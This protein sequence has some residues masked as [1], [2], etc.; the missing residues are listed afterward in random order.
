MNSRTLW[1]IMIVCALN[2][3]AIGEES[4]RQ[5]SQLLDAGS[6]RKAKAVLESVLNHEPQN[7][8]AHELLGDAY[9]HEGNAGAAE[10]EYKKAL[11]LGIRDSELLSNLATVNRWNHHFAEAR[12]LYKRELEFSPFPQDAQRE[13]D[14]LAYQ[15]GL[16]LFNS[17][18]GW[19][20]DST[21]KGWQTEGFYGG[22]DHVDPYAGASYSDKYFYTRRSYYGKA[23]AFFSPAF[24]TKFSFE[25]DT[26]NYPVA[27]TPV[28]DANAY[29]HVPTAGVELS[30]KLTSRV[31]GTISYEFF[32]PNFF[33]DQNEHVN[34]HKVSGDIDYQTAWKPLS[35]QLKA[36]TLRDPDPDRTVVD[37]TNHI[38]IPAYGK[39]F[40]AGGGG[41]FTFPRFEANVLILPNRDLDRSTSYSLLSACAVILHKDL[42]LRAG[43]VY[44][45][46]SNQSVF[47]GRIAQVYNAGLSWRPS[48]W[49]EISFGGKVVRRPVRNDQAIYVTT[50]F[51]LPIR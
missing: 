1:V 25:Q 37:K 30:G 50:R 39:Q 7:A 42:K 16:S 35:L 13:L 17:F 26:Y 29:R 31:Q 46:Y 20:T 10:R 41:T 28:P 34:N 49:S 23:Y 32:R 36:A 43:H 3:S 48:R 24:Y 14:D 22:I 18:G 27:I 33:F 8:R 40:L 47:S 12:K 44:D 2:L 21:T 51:R 4:I 6:T 9:R 38:V 5:A 11:D 19:E 15:R 45:S